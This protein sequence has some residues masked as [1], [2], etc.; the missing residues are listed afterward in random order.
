M[1]NSFFLVIPVQETNFLR[2]KDFEEKAL[3]QWVDE[4]PTANPELAT[5]LIHDFLTRFNALEMGFQLRLD[6]LEILRSSVLVIEDYLRSKLI[7]IGFPKD[8]EDINYFNVLVSIEK[9]FTIAYWTALK[10]LTRRSVSWFKGKQAALAMQRTIKGLSSIVVSHFIMGM[11]IPDWVWIDL[12]SLYKLSVKINKD[13]TKVANEPMSAAKASS[14]E[15]CYQQI[16]LLSLA[17][18]I[19]LMQKEILLVYDFIETLGAVVKLKNTPVIGQAVQCIVL[20]DEDKPPFFQTEVKA[21]PEP[22]RFYL[23]LSKLY[24]AIKQKIKSTSKSEARFSSIHKSRDKNLKPSGELLD[25]LEKR[26]QGTE[27][28]STPIF[29]DRLDRYIAVGFES[30]YKLQSALEPDT[31]KDLEYLVQS[32]S[33]RTLSCVFN[34]PGVL[35]VG[36]LISFRKTD[37]PEYKRALGI[38]NEVIVDNQNGK[39]SFG[40][41]LLAKQSIV[42]TYSYLDAPGQ[43]MSH[44]ALLY[45]VKDEKGENSYLITDT[46]LLNDNDIIRMLMGNE[47]FPVALNNKKNIGLGYWQY[48]CRRIMD[49]GKLPQI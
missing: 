20:S 29:T 4:L 49:T 34:K 48:E 36:S 24:K 47:V 10:E 18:P 5:R 28:R 39:I 21:S 31:N 7:N 41:Q 42:V 8:E 45:S 46:S 30:T 37:V 27:L 12:H 6:T 32:E 19:G 23:D 2:L 9:E 25:Y 1:K 3:Q 13:T 33:D 26:W 11:A 15:E 22:Y 38:V 44:R 17:L 43:A 14:P 35:S 40:I 16:L